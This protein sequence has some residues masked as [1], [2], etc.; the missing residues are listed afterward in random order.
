MEFVNVSEYSIKQ[1]RKLKKEKG[2][3]ATPKNYSREGI[4]RA[5]KLLITE[6]YG[7][8]AVSRICP[9]KKDCVSINL[10]DGSKEKVQKRLLLTN[11]NEVYALFKS[12]FSNLPVFQLLPFFTQNGVY[13]LVYQVPTM[14]VYAG[15]TKM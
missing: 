14:F 1:A 11:L 4:N 12:K 15:T 2:I 6:F 8:D 10:E 5:T 9:G 13:L 7:C 3:L